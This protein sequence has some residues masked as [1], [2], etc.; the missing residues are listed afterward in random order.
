MSLGNV[1]NNTCN[2]HFAT[3]PA[4]TLLHVKQHNTN[5][6]ANLRQPH[7][8]KPFCPSLVTAT[9][10]TQTTVTDLIVYTAR[11]WLHCRSTC[12]YH[13]RRNASHT[14]STSTLTMEVEAVTL[15][16]HWIARDVTVRPHIT[17][18]HSFSELATN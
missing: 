12:D 8:L 18:P 4:F 14:V 5:R 1:R 6:H 16:L 9:Y 15:S 10:V 11:V 2:T 13:P 3:V 17:I 7:V